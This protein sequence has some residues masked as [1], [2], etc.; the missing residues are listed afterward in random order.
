MYSAYKLNKQGDNIQPWHTPF[1]IWNQ[2]VVP[3]PVLTVASLY[4][5]ILL[6]ILAIIKVPR[7]SKLNSLEAKG[8]HLTDISTKHSALKGTNNQTLLWSKGMFLDNL[9]NLTRG[10]PSDSDS[11]ESVCNSG[12]LG[13]IPGS[14]RSPGRGTGATHS[15]I[16]AWRI[17]WTEES[18][19]RQSMESQRVGHNWATNTFTFTPKSQPQKRKKKLLE[20]TGNLIKREPWFE[21]NTNPVLPETLRFSF[22]TIAH[23]LNH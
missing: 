7:H 10:F 3:C 1:P 6:G 19:R 23:T 8:N 5:T 21:A 2:S 15:S 12:D 9:E 18:G 14:G 17:P 16:L 13:L 4:A 22:L 11:K 20:F